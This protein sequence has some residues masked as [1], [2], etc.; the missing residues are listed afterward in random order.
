[1][2][3]LQFFFFLFPIAFLAST[4]I[5]QTAAPTTIAPSQIVEREINLREAHFY[6]F[7]LNA[8]EFVR[9]DIEQRNV[10]PQLAVS[11]AKGEK[12][13]RMSYEK[14]A[15]ST[16]IFFIAPEKAQFRLTIQS[17]GRSAMNGN[18]RLKM[19]APRLA[20]ELDRRRIAA[21]VVLDGDGFSEEKSTPRTAKPSA[22]YWRT[23]LAALQNAAAEWRKLNEPL[24]EQQTMQQIGIVAGKL[25][26]DKISQAAFEKS[27]AL[28]QSN[29]DVFAEAAALARLA[30][31]AAKRGERAA[32]EEYLLK[33]LALAA[34]SNAKIAEAEYADGLGNHFADVS[35]YEKARDYLSKAAEL[36]R[37]LKS[38]VSEA[39]TRVSLAIVTERL[40]RKTDSSSVYKNA[41][42]VFERNDAFYEKAG[43]FRNLGNDALE[44]KQFEVAERYFA[45][46]LALM[47]KYGEPED[48]AFILL[49]FGLSKFNQTKYAE[50]GEFLEKAAAKLDDY[51]KP[52]HRIRI[53]TA[54]ARTALLQGK[55]A[56]SLTKINFA[57]E[58]ADKFQLQNERI[59]LN[60]L[61][62]QIYA[63]LGQNDLAF[64]H[65]LAAKKLSD[66]IKDK[67][68][69]GSSSIAL[70]LIYQFRG[71]YPTALVLL[72]E[73]IKAG[74]ESLQ[75]AMVSA[76]YQ[77]LGGLY[78]ELGDF[79]RAEKAYLKATDA[80]EKTANATIK[81]SVALSIAQINL[82]RNKFAEAKKNIET[83]L[84]AAKNDK[85]VLVEAYAEQLLGNL[86]LKEKDFNAAQ[87]RFNAA[88][89]LQTKAKLI[90]GIALSLQGL[91]DSFAGL[92]QKAQAQSVYAQTLGV[93]RQIGSPTGEATIFENLMNLESKNGNR[94]LAIFY[95][96]Q[97]VNILQTVRGSIKPLEA[98][99]R[100]SFLSSVENAYRTLAA[101]LI[102]ENRVAEARKVLSLLKE[103]EFYQY[104]RR[105]PAVA[106]DA[107]RRLDLTAEESAAAQKYKELTDRISTLTR[108]VAELGVKTLT[109]EEQTEMQ[110][111]QTELAGLNG[112]Y[113]GLLQELSGQFGQPET[114][115]VSVKEDLTKESVQA[116]Q[117]APGEQTILL[118][119]LLTE[120]RY[121]VIV[122]TADTQ[123]VRSVEISQADLTRKIVNLR[124]ILEDPRSNPMPVTQELY[125]ILVK[126]IEADLARSNAKTLLWSLDGALRYVPFAALHDGRNFL[127]EKYANV[128]VTLA[129]PPELSRSAPENWRA[130][131]AGVSAGIENL[132]GL[133]QVAAELKSIVRDE[134]AKN[135][136]SEKGLFS[137]RRLQ[138]GEFSRTNFGNALR[139]KNQLIHLATHFVFRPGK[140]TDSFLLLGGGDKL[141]LADLQKSDYFDLSGVELLTLSACETAVGTTDANGVEIESFGIIARRRGAKTVLASLWSIA[142]NSTPQLM[143]EFYGQ[144]Q[145]GKGLISKAEALRRAQ[146][147]LLKKNKT[148]R[149][150]QHPAYWGAFIIVGNL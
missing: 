19:T 122:T 115:D 104:T 21:E 93:F 29:R 144:Y 25:H 114:N 90:L 60:A 1:M 140:D 65:A 126:P 11:N 106:P 7:E 127:V 51:S 14:I 38:E 117:T 33:A 82:R 131:G 32:E 30:Q 123:T 76:G 79:N 16:A 73:G 81:K 148:G 62:S 121:Y 39:R 63:A 139:L 94:R 50:A 88:L 45:D 112:K 141:N 125:Q 71:D 64:K 147:M 74:E 83:V 120:N 4:V 58:I 78:T 142:D 52:A 69:Q 22:G 49:G 100:R 44:K 10:D 41:L 43:V 87:S 92:G 57:L 101:M 102:E 35:K 9:F 17:S 134:N 132:P 5:A 70:S 66:E 129:Q 28:A 8:D 55:I 15:G 149:N 12:L 85:D 72:E 31:T 116:K 137:G 75:D 97:S 105:N 80:A 36:Y 143:T 119:T 47:E 145:N 3:T 61:V 108:R 150:Y 113:G 54:Q 136:R 135:S 37:A 133:P 24:C 118:T 98:E 103:E 20:D 53:I 99:I 6:E 40:D 138:D 27:L 46:A 146:M 59:T 48:E 18:Y 84:A 96:K 124:E 13:R 107:P 128:L 95:G 2:R 109:P 26:D 89:A 34:Q 56:D 110:K 91:G 42:D 130:L 111:A 67:F 68:S 77:R 86:A 23:R